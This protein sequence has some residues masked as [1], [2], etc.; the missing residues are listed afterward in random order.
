[1]LNKKDTTPMVD[2]SNLSINAKPVQPKVKTR[3]SKAVVATVNGHKI[4]KKDA[5]AY[6]S[7]IKQVTAD[8]ILRVSQTY[9]V[10]ENLSIG[11]MA[12]EGEK[13]NLETDVVMSLFKTTPPKSQPQENLTDQTETATEMHDIGTGTDGVEGMK[14]GIDFIEEKTLTYN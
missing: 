10:P 5:D 11:L 13:I 4:I 12:P 2:L 6:L 14:R 9:L 7:K 1:M 3:S 8:D